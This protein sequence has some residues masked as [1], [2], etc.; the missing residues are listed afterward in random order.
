MEA[1]RAHLWTDG[2]SVH[3]QDYDRMVSGRHRVLYT[4]VQPGGGAVDEQSA[5]AG[6]LGRKADESVAVL[7]AQG[8][9]S[10]TV[11]CS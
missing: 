7:A 3:S 1:D 6:R 8:T 11:T 10:T 9:G 5:F 2:Q 4:G